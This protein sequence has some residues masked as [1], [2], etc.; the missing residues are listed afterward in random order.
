MKPIYDPIEFIGKVEFF[1]IAVVASFI[2]M[3][4]LNGIY[5]NMYEPVINTMIDSKDCN[6][7]YAKI[8]KYYVQI[9]SIIKEFIKWIVLIIILMVIYNIYAHHFKRK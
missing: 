2:T 7:Y 6:K 4:L 5:E 3:K 8:G 1:T 9:D